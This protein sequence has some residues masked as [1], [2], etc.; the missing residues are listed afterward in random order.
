[1]LRLWGAVG[2]GI[3][4]LLAGYVSDSHGGSYTGVMVVFLANVLVALAAST[5]VRV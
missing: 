2:F 5:G 4:S 3:A 1:M